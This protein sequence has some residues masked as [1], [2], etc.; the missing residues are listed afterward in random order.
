[1]LPSAA[2]HVFYI[3]VARLNKLPFPPPVL[4]E[5]RQEDW[6]SVLQVECLNVKLSQNRGFLQ[7][8]HNAAWSIR[9]AL[10]AEFMWWLSIAI[11]SKLLAFW[12]FCSPE[13]RGPRRV[14]IL[15]VFISSRLSIIHTRSWSNRW[16]VIDA[17]NLHHTIK[18]DQQNARSELI[19]LIIADGASLSPNFVFRTYVVGGGSGRSEFGSTW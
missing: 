14:H 7:W 19:H 16:I 17:I 5:L 15:S 10:F 4:Q 8:C 9:Y 3:S 1:M 11:Q 18:S 2:P 12:C 13:G 6:R